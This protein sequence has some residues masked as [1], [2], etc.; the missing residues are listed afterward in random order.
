MTPLRKWCEKRQIGITTAYQLLKDGKLKAVKLGRR[1]Y[2]TD[3]EDQRFIDS[4]P[5][6]LNRMGV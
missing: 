2:I 6:Y 4:L 3:T 1:T 5:S